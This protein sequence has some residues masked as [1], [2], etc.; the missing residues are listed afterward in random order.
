MTMAILASLGQLT[1]N[2]LNLLRIQYIWRQGDSQSSL[3]ASLREVPTDKDNL[4]LHQRV[5]D[6]LFSVTPIRKI[7]DEEYTHT[8]RVKTECARQE[9]MEV[10]SQLED[11][12]SAL[13]ELRTRNQ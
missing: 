8:L 13:Q 12:E 9:L 5:V 1:F 2:E 6:A 7:S 3:E 4:P 10:T 11:V